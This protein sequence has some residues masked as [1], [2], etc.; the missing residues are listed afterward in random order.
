MS[1]SNAKVAQ[2]QRGVLKNNPVQWFL[3]PSR[4]L[5]EIIVKKELKFTVGWKIY[6]TRN[7]WIHP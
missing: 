4:T 1:P 6:Y 3:A 2:K 7:I 5:I